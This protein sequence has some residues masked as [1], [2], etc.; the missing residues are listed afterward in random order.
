M[1]TLF[2]TP[3]RRYC[4]CEMIYSSIVNEEENIYIENLSNF[5]DFTC[6][7]AFS[8]WLI[9]FTWLISGAV[10]LKSIQEHKCERHKAV[11][12]VKTCICFSQHI[13]QNKMLWNWT[14]DPMLHYS[15][16]WFIE[17]FLDYL[18]KLFNVT[19]YWSRNGKFTSEWFEIGLK[20]NNKYP[21]VF[22]RYFQI[23]QYMSGGVETK[24]E[25]SRSG[26]LASWSTF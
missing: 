22:F 23:C 4:H 10:W 15:S 3:R 19:R 9:Y 5:T 20:G 6:N 13:L 1:F 2:F 14:L 18:T 17:W 7:C 24:S 11:S 8:Q 12:F 16:R 21:L 26:Y 25:I